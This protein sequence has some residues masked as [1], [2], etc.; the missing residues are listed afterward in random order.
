[1]LG[2]I[3]LWE[4]GEIA[5][6]DNQLFAENTFAWL[7]T[8]WLLVTPTSGI[9]AG[10]DEFNVGLLVDRRQYVS[11][12]YGLMILHTDDSDEALMAIPVSL[13]QFLFLPFAV[14]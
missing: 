4:N 10:E 14:K 6:P 2:D 1:V 3:N 11:G 7:A 12:E 13:D 8:S 5:N 9:V